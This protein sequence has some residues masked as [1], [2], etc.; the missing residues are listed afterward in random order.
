MAPPLPNSAHGDQ[1]IPAT[2][3]GTARF[4]SDLHMWGGR[5]RTSASGN[6]CPAGFTAVV[7]CGEGRSCTRLLES[8]ARPA[9]TLCSAR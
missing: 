1:L 6:L 4:L 5:I 8:G 2:P 7:P 3:R 9:A